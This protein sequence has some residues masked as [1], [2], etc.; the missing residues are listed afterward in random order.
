MCGGEFVCRVLEFCT[1]VQED[2]RNDDQWTDQ[3]QGSSPPIL[4]GWH[5]YGHITDADS[6]KVQPHDAWTMATHRLSSHLHSNHHMCSF[7]PCY[8]CW[9]TCF[10]QQPDQ[11]V[12]EPV[13]QS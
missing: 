9:W 3:L 8:R 1:C 5:W 10:S 4:I 2:L 11:S 12:S 13:S 6:V 7:V